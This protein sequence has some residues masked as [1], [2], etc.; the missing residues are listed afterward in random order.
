MKIWKHYIEDILRIWS[1]RGKYSG[2]PFEA[3]DKILAI[4]SWIRSIFY[5]LSLSFSTYTGLPD[6]AGPAGHRNLDLGN[7]Q[8]WHNGTHYPR[9]SGR[10][11]KME[12]NKQARTAVWHWKPLLLLLLT[13]YNVSNNKQ[14]GKG[15]VWHW[16]S[17][18]LPTLS[19]PRA[20]RPG[21]EEGVEKDLKTYFKNPPQSNMEERIQKWFESIHWIHQAKAEKKT[22]WILV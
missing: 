10:D 20:S 11:T 8:R 21:L 9:Q 22:S 19:Q 5:M 16:K 1:W 4:C 3:I 12:D 14:A 15:S 13:M 6:P 2:H 7:I 18:I 17:R